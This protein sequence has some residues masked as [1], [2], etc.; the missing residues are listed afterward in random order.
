MQ[1]RVLLTATGSGCGKTTITIALLKA[2]KQR[3][4]KV[5]SF[6]CGPDYIDPMYHRETLG[7][8]SYNL[9]PFFCDQEGLKTVLSNGMKDCDIA[10]LEG[11]MGYYDGIGTEGKAST[12]EVATQT[13]TPA[14]LIVNA[15][16]MSN[17]VGAVIKGFLSY[18]KNHQICGVIFNQCSKGMYPLLSTIAEKEGVVPLGYMP[19]K[20]ELSLESRHL[21]LLTANEVKDLSEKIE[22]LGEL[23]E[24]CLS[25]DGILGLAEKSGDIETPV[26]PEERKNCNLRLAVAKDEAFCFLYQENLE[27]LEKAGCEL[28]YFSPLFDVALPEDC[29]GLYLP[30]GYPELYLEKLSQ[31]TEMRKNMKAAIQEGM[32]TIAECGGFL[33]LHENLEGNPMVGVISGNASKM[34][35][36]VRF[37]YGTMEGKTDSMLLKKGEQIRIHEFHYFD[38][39]QNGNDMMITKASN[40][41]VYECAYATSSLYAGYPHLY[42]PANPSVADH[43]VQAMKEYKEK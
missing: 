31:N 14:I 6:K 22:A 35:K 28:I 24:E 18:Q 39:E 26:S 29:H 25:L 42:F 40:G 16:G 34:E 19:Y 36:L 5:A 37:G 8:P 2:L 17:S 11:V 27:V 30:G 12:W 7:I 1:P 15:K 33:Y 9:D 10:L 23:A 20:P 4:L 21:G 38:S 3:G 32:P 43:F 13:D 41:K